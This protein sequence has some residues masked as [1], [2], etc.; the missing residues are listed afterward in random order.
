MTH[1][2]CDIIEDGRL[3]MRKAGDSPELAML[4]A[5]QDN[6][7]SYPDEG[8]KRGFYFL[9]YGA[10]PETNWTKRDLS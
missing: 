6:A 8:S 5:Y 4:Y 9:G 1:H 10:W 2:Y 7:T 3:V